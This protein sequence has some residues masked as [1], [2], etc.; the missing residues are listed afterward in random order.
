M[1]LVTRG[2]IFVVGAGG[3]ALV[4]VGVGGTSR[5]WALACKVARSSAVV[6]NDVG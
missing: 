5:V 2:D 1:L 3:G 6:A 4:A